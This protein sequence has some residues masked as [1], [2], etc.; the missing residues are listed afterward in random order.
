MAGAKPQRMPK[1]NN[2]T[3]RETG[4]FRKTQCSK[5]TRCEQPAGALS[6][7]K[8]TRQFLT[9]IIVLPYFCASAVREAMGRA[10]RRCTPAGTR[11][12]P[13]CPS[14]LARLGG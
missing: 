9:G 3:Q 6:K 10:L 1:P 12:V 8:R 2:L 5:R 13:G 7:K 11:A 4:S 14:K